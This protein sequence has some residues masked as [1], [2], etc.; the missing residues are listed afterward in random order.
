MLLADV[1]LLAA[2]WFDARRAIPLGS[3]GLTSTREAP[4]AFSVGRPGEVSYRWVSAT[5][6]RARLR[7]REVRPDLLGGTQPP[8]ELSVPARGERRE[9]LAVVPRRRGREQAGAF[10]VDS[11]GPLGLGVRRGTLAAP[12]DPAGYPPLLRGPLRASAAPAP[13]RQQGVTAIRQLGRGRRFESLREWGP[14]EDL[15]HL[16]WKA[17]DK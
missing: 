14:G 16:D 9:T 1:A 11:I 13:R 17:N 3:A 7:V 6:R 5:R 15:G 10:V 8:R 12:R 2:V 4:P